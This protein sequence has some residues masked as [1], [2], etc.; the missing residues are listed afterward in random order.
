MQSLSCYEFTELLIATIGQHRLRIISAKHSE[1][2]LFCRKHNFL[3]YYMVFDFEI[4]WLVWI[5]S[6]K[7]NWKHAINLCMH[8]FGMVCQQ[9]PWQALQIAWSAPFLI[10]CTLRSNEL[11][12]NAKLECSLKVL[13]SSLL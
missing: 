10:L 7:R 5:C 9:S 4:L 8:F 13:L 6:G 1:R 2:E 3:R 12:L 11:Q